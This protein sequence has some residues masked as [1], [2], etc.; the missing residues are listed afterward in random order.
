LQIIDLFRFWLH[1][2]VYELEVN[3]YRIF[4]LFLMFIFGSIPLKEQRQ[5]KTSA[6]FAEY[7]KEV[8]M[9]IP[10]PVGK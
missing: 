5:M 7:K 9:L 1:L 10:L 2:E 6:D 4:K 3:K 8:S